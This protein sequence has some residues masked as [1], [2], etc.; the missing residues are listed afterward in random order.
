MKHGLSVQFRL[1]APGG[2][3]GQRRIIVADGVTPGRAGE[4]QFSRDIAL[5]DG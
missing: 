3:T 1:L 4:D 2:R 5:A